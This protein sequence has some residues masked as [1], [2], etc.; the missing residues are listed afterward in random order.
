M[1]SRLSSLGKITNRKP[2]KI[3][4]FL[5]R[6]F[7][8]LSLI[9]LVGLPTAFLAA[10]LL[11]GNHTET[12]IL[13]S[14]HII[15]VFGASTFAAFLSFVAR[16]CYRATGR[17]L[18]HWVSL[19]F[20]GFGIIYVVHGLLTPWSSQHMITFLIFGPVSRL[21]MIIFLLL[22]VKSEL[23][24]NKQ[25][26]SQ[27]DLNELIASKPNTLLLYASAL[28]LLVCIL[29]LVGSFVSINALRAIEA[30][31]FALSLLTIVLM[32]R[33]SNWSLLMRF[34][35]LGLSFLAQASLIFVFSAPWNALWWFAHGVSAIGF[36]LIAYVV[37]K[38]YESVPDL[39]HVYDEV[40]FFRD[41]SQMLARANRDLEHEI[42]QRARLECEL[43]NSI[44]LIN[45]TK[46][47]KVQLAEQNALLISERN[48]LLLAEQ[49]ARLLVE[50]NRLLLAERNAL[51]L[52]ERNDKALAAAELVAQHKSHFIATMSHEIRTP[53]AV[54]KGYTELALKE[55][56]A[57]SDYQR[58][59]TNIM[60]ACVHL[61]GLINNILDLSKIE[62]GE[63]KIERSDVSLQEVIDK[64]MKLFEEKAKAKQLVFTLRTDNDLPEVI[65]TDMIRLMQILINIL[66]NAI[67]FTDQG[68]VEMHVAMCP[69]TRDSSLPLLAFIISDEGI[70][71]EAEQEERLFKSFSQA[72]SSITRR[73]GG[74][75]LGLSLSRH[76]ARL[77]GG[78]VVFSRSRSK[79]SV[80]TI[81]VA[82]YMGASRIDKAQVNVQR[83]SGEPSPPVHADQLSL[84][85]FNILV[86]EDAPDLGYLVVHI[87]ESCGAAVKL[88][89]NGRE[90]IEA[91]KDSRFDVVLMDIHMP[92]LGGYEATRQLRQAQFT[93]P[94]FAMTAHVMAGERERCIA[95]GFT[96]YFSKPINIEKMID[97]IK[98]LRS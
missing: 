15:V 34:H 59:I 76:L 89:A 60:N 1:V 32:W 83:A 27:A 97:A 19:A 94:I 66:G 9:A 52:A 42:K 23:K 79:G 96:D 46:K 58:W 67:K 48:A 71:V 75:G 64:A 72:D 49:N 30:L 88:V 78:D 43:R 82:P 16:A 95:L 22:G 4:R 33:L 84:V 57:A 63:I 56:S 51:L 68:Q 50:K 10:F 38:A 20:L 81:T 28:A 26:I 24:V 69:G 8:C 35:L 2:E 80:F 36:F 3:L 70:G 39:E 7:S 47:S 91:V 44:E 86:A 87:L 45:I 18:L 74:T 90:A 98:S 61:E 17:L 31:A 29:A 62:A 85:G 14:F 53:L 21:V 54:I 92:I 41:R 12:Y 55:N 6:T 13:H 77:L 11:F 5:C 25:D 93:I 73:F 40:I 37:A 65:N